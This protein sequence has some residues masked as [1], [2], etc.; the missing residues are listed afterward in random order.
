MATETLFLQIRSLAKQEKPSVSAASEKDFVKNKYSQ[1]IRQKR[2]EETPIMEKKSKNPHKI[3][4]N[5]ESLWKS[6]QKAQIGICC[7]N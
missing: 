4:T 2:K 7:W 6:M 1:R 3:G 5:E